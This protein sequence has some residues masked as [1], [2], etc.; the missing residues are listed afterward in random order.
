MAD[1][2][3]T[4]TSP[5]FPN[6]IHCSIFH[7]SVFVDMQLIQGEETVHSDSVVTKKQ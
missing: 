3:T 4:I 1:P 7:I 2:R 6:D 5:S